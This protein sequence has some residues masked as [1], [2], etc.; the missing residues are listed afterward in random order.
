MPRFG[1]THLAY[2]SLFWNGSSWDLKRANSKSPDKCQV[3]FCR[4][5]PYYEYRRR[6]DKFV[7][8]THSTCTKCRARRWR[9]NNP[10][11]SVYKELRGSA[12]K[13]KIPFTLTIEHLEEVC[14][15]SG[16]LA[17]KGCEGF[18]L[19]IDRIRAEGGY[20]DGNIQVLTCSENV[21]K[22]NR[23]RYLPEYVKALRARQEEEIPQF[24]GAD[25]PF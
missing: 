10:L 2:P 16:Y 18:N 19:H 24:E 1:D 12:R 5:L 6:G 17:L 11:K 3:V 23:E 9:A 4:N 25:C 20:E 21:A 8:T 7:L 15:D 14:E 22:G 13:R